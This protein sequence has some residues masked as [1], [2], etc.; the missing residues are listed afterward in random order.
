MNK[1]PLELIKMEDMNNQLSVP[2]LDSILWNKVYDEVLQPL[3]NTLW[4]RLDDTLC[5]HINEL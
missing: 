5:D 4:R 2:Q 1:I 3:R